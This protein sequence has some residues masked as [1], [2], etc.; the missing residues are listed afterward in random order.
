LKK[1]FLLPIAFFAVVQFT[2]AATCTSGSLAS[3]IA[4]GATGC[5]IGSDTL[6]NFQI[7]PGITGATAIPGSTLNIAI[8]GGSLSPTLSFATSQTAN[9]G[10]LLEAIFTYDISGPSYNSASIALTNSSETLDGAV[11]EIEN[12]C[13]GGSFGSDGVDGCTGVPGSLLTLDGIQNQDHSNLGPA[14]FLQITDDFTLD[15][16]TAGSAS[17]GVFTNTFTAASATA[18]PEPA[19]IFFVALGLAG[20]GLIRS[21]KSRTDFEQ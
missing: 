17:G 3:Y 2:S 7:I 8:S 11:A 19:S 18:T 1:L 20:A 9:T 4:L 13:A 10:S 15:G 14:S 5:E 6:S 12:F 16:G 21:R